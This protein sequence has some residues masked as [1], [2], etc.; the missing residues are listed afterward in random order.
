MHG[1]DQSTKSRLLFSDS[2]RE[3]QQLP[4]GQ[5]RSLLPLLKPCWTGPFMYIGYGGSTSSA[6]QMLGRFTRGSCCIGVGGAVYSCSDMVNESKFEVYAEAA[7]VVVFAKKASGGAGGT[8]SFPRSLSICR[9]VDSASRRRCWKA[10]ITS[11]GNTH[12]R[13]MIR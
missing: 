6:P 4:V 7:I 5:P 10:I 11:Y 8:D 3:L 13:D 1:D 12:C 9:P 2:G